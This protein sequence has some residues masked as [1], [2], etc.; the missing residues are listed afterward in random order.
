MDIQAL[1]E[2]MADLFATAGARMTIAP[3]GNGHINDTFLLVTHAP[4]GQQRYILQRLNGSVFLHPKEVMENIIGVTHYLAEQKKLHDDL[5]RMQVLTLVPAK[6]GAPYLTDTDGNVWRLYD[7]V[8]HTVSHEKPDSP[9]WFE[10][11]GCGFGDFF[12][13][14]GSYPAKTLHETIVNFHNT[15]VRLAQL[16]DAIARDP[17]GRVKEVSSEIAFVKG[18]RDLI[19]ALRSQ[20]EDGSLPL[21]VTHNDTKLNNVLLDEQTGESVCVIDLDTVMPG[22]IAYD[23]GDSIR[24]GTNTAAEDE[25]DLRKCHFSMELYEA[26][27]RGYL[28]HAGSALTDAEVLSLPMGAILMTLECGI[29]FLADHINGDVYFKIHREGHNLDRC[30]TQFKLVAE[31]VAQREKMEQIV[32]SLH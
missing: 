25:Q 32:L 4:T 20:L 22:L 8:E 23:F 15:P 27:A 3:Y 10:N 30:R 24:F 14:L 6:S 13:L 19:S 16:E 29:R 31:M 28:A 26:F 9:E 7:F 17:M 1:A 11:S 2:I 18:H 12:R 21:R 5:T